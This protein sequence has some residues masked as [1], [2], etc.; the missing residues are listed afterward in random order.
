[1][2][3]ECNVAAS[4]FPRPSRGDSRRY[5]AKPLARDNKLRLVCRRF[6]SDGG[7]AMKSK[8]ISSRDLKAKLNMRAL[9]AGRDLHS[10]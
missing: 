3:T 10:H 4:A 9:L 2:L 6:I 5:L 7:V 8:S 1:M